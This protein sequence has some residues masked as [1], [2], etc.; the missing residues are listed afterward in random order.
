[1]KIFSGKPSDRRNLYTITKRIDSGKVAITDRSRRSKTIAAGP[2]FSVGD[3][4]LVVSGVLVGATA[5]PKIKI[6]EV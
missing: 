4:V 2:E 1:M 5:K 3:S 6:I